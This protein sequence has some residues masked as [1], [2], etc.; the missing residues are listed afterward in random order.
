MT[1]YGFLLSLIPHQL[2]YILVL[3]TLGYAV[4]SR[5]TQLIQLTCQFLVT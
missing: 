4:A 2:S 1:R 3:E 5:L